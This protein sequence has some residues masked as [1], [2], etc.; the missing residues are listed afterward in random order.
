MNASDDVVAHNIID[1]LSTTTA[2]VPFAEIAR[3]ARAIGRNRLAAL[4]CLWLLVLVFFL[5]PFKCAIM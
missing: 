1:K 5:C 2:I 3:S 4:V